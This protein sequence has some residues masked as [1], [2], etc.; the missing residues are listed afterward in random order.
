MLTILSF[1][2]ALVVSPL[3]AS[4]SEV[5]DEQLSGAVNIGYKSQYVIGPGVQLD[6]KA[7]VQSSVRLDLPCTGAYL[8][9]W[10]S[11]G[12]DRKGREVDWTVGIADSWQGMNWDLSVSLFDL[13]S[14]G[15]F[16][17][18]DLINMQILANRGTYKVP[19]GTLLPYVDIDA[20]R[21]IDEGKPVEVN[22]KGGIVYGVPLTDATTLRTD[23]SYMRVNALRSE[24]WNVANA[25]M[26]FDFTL[27]DGK[28]TLTPSIE[29]SMPFGSRAPESQTIASVNVAV[30]F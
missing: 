18:E 15:N 1:L 6:D 13:D 28:F 2:A 30:P 4:A 11:F 16:G 29:R 8:D 20:L 23:V 10:T 25:N 27:F 3:G 21:A 19:G 22:V 7:V 26:A 24:S 17:G 14:Q 5:C 12:Q 9:V